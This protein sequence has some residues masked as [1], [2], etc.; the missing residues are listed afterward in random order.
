[1]IPFK[2]D[3]IN[4]LVISV[5]DTATSIT[6]LVNTAGSTTDELKNAIDSCL[7]V[8]ED[9]SIRLA[10]ETAPTSTKGILIDINETFALSSADMANVK[11]IRTG[12]SNVAVSLYFGKNINNN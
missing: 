7:L 5:T 11:L 1:M 3:N 2:T 10:Y 6:D 4:N 9:G 12:G 8:P